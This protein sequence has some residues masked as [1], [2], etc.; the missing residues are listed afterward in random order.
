MRTRTPLPPLT[1]PPLT[2]PPLTAVLRSH[3]P[4]SS[5]PGSQVASLSDMLSVTP[6]EIVTKLRF[7][8]I[9]IFGLFGLMHVLA[10]VSALRDR[11]SARA[12][13]ARLCG[14]EFGFR[15]DGKAWVWDLRQVRPVES[16]E[17]CSCPPALP[18]A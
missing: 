13:L 16:L 15:E 6:A 10:A 5:T 9:V 17:N 4:V 11:A 3:H 1:P 12:E 2:P 18:A 7:I 8:A 14:A